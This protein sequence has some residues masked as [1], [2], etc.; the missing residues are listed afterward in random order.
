M[1][2]VEAL[3][4]EGI[5]LLEISGGTFESAVMFDEGG[6]SS[7]STR[8]R[9]AFFMDYAEKVRQLTDVPLMVTGG[10]RTAPGMRDALESGAVDL[11]GMARPFAVEPDL[12]RRLL[13]GEADAA[14]E[15]SLETGIE[16]LDSLV[17][18]AWYQAQLERLGAGDTPDPNLSRF[19]AVLGYVCRDGASTDERDTE[20][21]TDE[22]ARR[23][24]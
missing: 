12:P 14:A 1:Q 22:V 19:K 2:V 13:S 8:R 21:E 18:G 17:Q 6:P 4:E 10:F 7:E 5:D 3:E 20:L 24:A 11:V 15:I 23:A 9:E 16:K